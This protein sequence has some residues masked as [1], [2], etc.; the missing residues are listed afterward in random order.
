VISA[1]LLAA[2]S[3]RRFGG[4]HKLLTVIP[5][6]GA[7]APLVRATVERL[8]AADGIAEII[9]V[10]GRD[11]E[12]V[13][14]AVGHS[15][16]ALQFV[17]NRDHEK[18]MSTSLREGVNAA[19]RHGDSLDGALVALAD[20]PELRSDVVVAIVDEFCR[21]P[22][23][24]RRD[25]IVV[26]RY[27]GAVGHPV[28]FGARVLPEL[29]ALTGDRGGRAVIERDGARVHH[30]DFAFGAPADI[31]TMNDLS[32]LLARENVRPIA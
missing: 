13:R 15:E 5:H 11:A 10:L 14:E 25:V 8:L 6:R 24:H 19:R 32:S 23:S 20:Q 12:R 29:L 9:V 27:A 22:K 18:G 16:A 21:V 28:L 4:E 17:C 26:P 2:G 30:V 31:D 3:A 1:I 7:A